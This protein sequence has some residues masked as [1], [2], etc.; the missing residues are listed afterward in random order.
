MV[1]YTNYL[2]VDGLFLG[3]P[4]LGVSSRSISNSR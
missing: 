3:G 2:L 4:W 1:I